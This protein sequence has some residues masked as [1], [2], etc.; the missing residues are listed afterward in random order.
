MQSSLLGFLLI[1]LPEQTDWSLTFPSGDPLVDLAQTDYSLSSFC[2]VSSCHIPPPPLALTYPTMNQ[3][4]LRALPTPNS[5][6]IPKPCCV[7]KGQGAAHFSR[8]KTCNAPIPAPSA[9]SYGHPGQAWMCWPVRHKGIRPWRQTVSTASSRHNSSAAP[10]AVGSHAVPVFGFHPP[11]SQEYCTLFCTATQIQ[12]ER[13]AWPC[14][15]LGEQEIETFISFSL[16][17]R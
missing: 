17:H 14:T 3:L 1:Q 11:W 13:E 9:P 12:N 5:M 10:Q 2:W 16:L 15:Q 7:D 6:S 8:P 4:K